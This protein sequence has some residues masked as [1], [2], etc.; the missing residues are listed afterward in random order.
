MA[1]ARV[2]ADAR[3]VDSV[4]GP[5]AE[6]GEGAVLR[7]GTWVTALWYAPGKHVGAGHPDRLRRQF[8]M[9]VP[10]HCRQAR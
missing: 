10:A 5:G 8:L 9:S 7:R 6:V 2:G 3:V 4:L 1:G